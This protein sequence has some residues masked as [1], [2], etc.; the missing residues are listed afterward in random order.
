VTIVG[1]PGNSAGGIRFISGRGLVLDQVWIKGF[2]VGIL[3]RPNTAAAGGVPSQLHI[4][5][6]VIAESISPTSGNI[7]IANIGAVSVAATLDR[8]TVRNGT[9]GVEV[10]GH[11]G[12]GQ[13]DVE[14]NESVSAA[15]TGGGYI[16]DSAAG[17]AHVNLK[18][19]NSVAHNNASF[20]ALATGAQ[21]FMIVSRSSLAR[22]GVGLAQQ[23]GST[24]ATYTN[25][26]I[27]FNDGGNNTS[28]TI[29]NIPQK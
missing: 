19:T 9:H 24:V 8:V 5:N 12:T 26:D 6:S 29:T 28:G 1:K 15:H 20:G 21:A 23:S 17:Q 3:F 7:F 11:L 10:Y 25:N 18:V 22:N 14:V 27:N 2:D 16:A 13:I 4:S